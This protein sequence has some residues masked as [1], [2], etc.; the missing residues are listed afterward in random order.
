MTATECPVPGCGKRSAP[1][2][3][4]NLCSMHKSRRERHGDINGGKVHVSPEARFER[5]VDKAAVG[6]CWEWMSAR[7]SAGYGRIRVPSETG[8]G[9][10]IYAHRWSYEHH[11]GPIPAGLMV[12]HACDNPPCVNPTHLSLGTAA[13]NNA[14]A[15]RKGRVSNQYLAARR[16]EASG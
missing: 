8:W 1:K 13:E 10:Q 7:S 15:S 11:V 2:A 6:G 12:M 5:Y 14:D 9:K 16:R 4:G 3:A